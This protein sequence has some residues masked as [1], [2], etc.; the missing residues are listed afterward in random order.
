LKRFS[1]ACPAFF[2]HPRTRYA[3]L[4][5]ATTIAALLEAGARALARVALVGPSVRV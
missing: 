3:L 2:R 5:F 1:I 4:G